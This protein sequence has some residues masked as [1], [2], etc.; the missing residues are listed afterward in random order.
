MSASR[1]NGP[2][3][4]PSQGSPGAR[5]PRVA[6]LRKTDRKDARTEAPEEGSAVSPEQAEQEQPERNGVAQSDEAVA[7]AENG[8]SAGEEAT[9][10]V[11]SGDESGS[12]A[13]E[14]ES[15]AAEDSEA[16]ETPDAD[17]TQQV[18]VEPDEAEEVSASQPSGK[19]PAAAE[20]PPDTSEPGARAVQ[21]GQ[22]EGQRRG[23]PVLIASLLV[24][25]LICAVLAVWFR[26]EERQLTADGPAANKALVDAAATSQINGQVTDAV[27]K[28][29]SYN[30]ADTGKTERA[31]KDLLTGPAV[32]QYEQLFTTVKQQA[33]VQKLVLT[34]TVKASGVTRLEDDR[35]QVLLF[36][37]QNAV[38][39]DSGQNNIGPAQ[40]SVN[41]E[42]SGDQWKISSITLR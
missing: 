23:G 39:T 26:Y 34:T 22:P 8:S 6:G 28:L 33:P 27:E 14:P 5:R 15:G 18:K 42:K 32:A 10:D 3:N 7:S 29:F 37:D 21:G 12:E 38:R 41:V 9:A 40:V 25:A 4:G 31:A 1:R 24:A 20:L 35:A 13:A 2:S 30:F 36:V 11:A 19:Q 17:K 16:G